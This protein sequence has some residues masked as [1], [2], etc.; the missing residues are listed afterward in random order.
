VDSA[1][2]KFEEIKSNISICIVKIVLPVL[3][4]GLCVHEINSWSDALRVPGP[5]H[6][7]PCCIVY[8][9]PSY[10]DPFDSSA[11]TCLIRVAI[12][13]IGPAKSKHQSCDIFRCETGCILEHA[14]S[15]LQAALNN[16]WIE[17]WSASV[18]PTTRHM[19][20]RVY[21]SK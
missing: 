13:Y 2:M 14:D 10:C 7:V 19:N 20:V 8:H 3:G 12:I 21:E 5:A 17:K 11:L 1:R 6:I 15:E 18:P 16:S 9:G 4:L